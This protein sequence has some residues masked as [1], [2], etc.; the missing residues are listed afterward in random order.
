MDSLGST[1][2]DQYYIWTSR[3]KVHTEKVNTD[4]FIFTLPLWMCILKTYF[5]LLW[6]V[7]IIFSTIGLSA[8]LAAL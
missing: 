5:I 6:I 2:L 3:Q 7:I 4:K 1:Q 8:L